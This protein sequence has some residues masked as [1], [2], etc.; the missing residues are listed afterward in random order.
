[1]IQRILSAAV[2][3]LAVGCGHVGAL[4]GSDAGTDGDTDSDAD[5]DTGTHDFTGEVSLTHTAYG[6][7]ASPGDDLELRAKFTNEDVGYGGPGWVG[8]FATPGGASCDIFCLSP[9]GDP[10]DPLPQI[11]AG[12][13]RAGLHGGGDYLS[14][15]FED[16]A[17]TVDLR[18]EGDPEHPKVTD[19]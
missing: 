1:M 13:I 8:T 18:S 7:D 2:L 5:T 6:A 17:Y 10:P 16:G 19:R 15:T 9:L 14:V 3:W 12:E 4:G 11:D